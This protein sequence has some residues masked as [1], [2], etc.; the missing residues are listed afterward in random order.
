MSCLKDWPFH[1]TFVFLLVVYTVVAKLIDSLRDCLLNTRKH[2]ESPNLRQGGSL[3]SIQSSSMSIAR[4]HQ[5]KEVPPG[6][7]SQFVCIFA[8]SPQKISSAWPISNLLRI[9]SKSI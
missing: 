3:E 1:L 2:S 4:L 8:P 6:K 5:S 7:K 9:S